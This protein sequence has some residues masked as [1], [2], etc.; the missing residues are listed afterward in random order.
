[1][2]TNRIGYLTALVVLAASAALGQTE[3]R[4]AYSYVREASGDVTV[5]SGL[6]GSVEARPNL[7]ISPGDEVRT[8]EPGRAE[9]ALADG[10]VLHVGGGTAVQFVSLYGQQG[11][12]D[13]V[14]A[15]SLKQGSVLLSVIGSDEKAVPRIDTEDVAIYTNPGARVRVNADQR[16]GTAVI[17]RA[18]SVEVRTKAGSYTV[19]AGNYLLAHGEEEPEIARGGFS[20]DR[21]DS[22]AADRL[23]ATYDSPRNASSQYVG[24]DYASDVSSLD[25]NGNWDYNS[26]YSTY[27][28]RP[29]VAAGWTPYSNGS[30]YYTPAGLTWWSSDS[31][32][33]YPHHYGNWFFDTGWNN[34]CW[35]PGNVYSPAWV[36]WGYTP[37]YVGWCP[38]GWYGGFSPWWNNYYRNTSYSRASLAFAINGNFST[39]RVDLR[40]WN[41]TGASGFGSTRGRI[42]VVPGTRI[43]DRLGEKL[44]ISSRPIVVTARTGVG[45]RDSLRD[46]VREA[47]RVIER[48]AGRDAQRLEPVVAR[49]RELPRETVEALRGRMVVA[50]RGRLSG[51]GAMDLAPRGAT[52]VERGRGDAQIESTKRIETDRTTGR[53]VLRDG[54]RATAAPPSSDRTARPESRHM[55]TR[56][57]PTESWRGRSNV[58]QRGRSTAEAPR[59]ESGAPASESW[60]ASP[61]ATQPKAGAPPSSDRTARPESRHMDTR[62]EPSESWR[63][64]SNVEQ[65][66]RS[67]A[68]APRRESGAPAS[69][70]WRASPRATQ[71]KAGAPPSSHRFE[72]DQ[73]P[74]QDWRSRGQVP[75]ARRVI[76]GAVPGRRSPETG[77]FAPPRS[78]EFVP[79][80]APSAPRRD[81]PRSIERA[82]APVQP[83]P[84]QQPQAAPPPSHSAPSRSYSAPPPSRPAPSNPGRP[85]RP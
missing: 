34:W 24:E 59:R 2:N 71:P 41:F 68:E 44:A 73:R 60:R 62:S 27:V 38:L 63:G 70:S 64:R 39:R 51:A 49:D 36:Y 19:R 56:S 74:V 21:F 72:S 1:M 10:N 79:R 7:P 76:E 61:R 80:E 3:R 28:W 55:D 45:V 83:A 20:R 29:R 69:E 31:W 40:G 25:G 78:N 57:E 66:G 85:G 81:A 52:I 33:W 22:W 9:I 47:P 11:S 65:R 54:G 14:S 18:G 8:D 75:P 12:D 43:V 17:V 48:T 4:S 84:R 50:E 30:W 58:E 42:D 13:E 26:S 37:S 82:P 53:T 16:R 46:Y 32:G 67:T 23:Q 35:A 5:I 77:N 15:L 6:N